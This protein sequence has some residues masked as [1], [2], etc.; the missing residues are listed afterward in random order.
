VGAELTLAYWGSY[1]FA[2]HFAGLPNGQSNRFYHAES[3]QVW[4]YDASAI[5]RGKRRKTGA[6]KERVVIVLDD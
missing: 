5:E 4:R 1:K 2:L 6:G 3:F